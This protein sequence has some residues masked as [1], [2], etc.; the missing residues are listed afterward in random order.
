MQVF[1]KT[2]T[3]KTLTLDVVPNESIESVKAKLEA[4]EGIPAD[5]M[6]LVFGGKQL[7]N[8]KTLEDYNIRRIATYS[9]YCDS[10]EAACKY[11]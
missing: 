11:S 9:S 10:V 2:L 5:E 1:V 7:D 8:G 4:R 6:R 3:G